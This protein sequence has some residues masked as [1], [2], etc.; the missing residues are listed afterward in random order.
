MARRNVDDDLNSDVVVDIPKDQEHRFGCLGR[1]LKPSRASVEALIAKIPCGMVMTTSCLRNALAESYNA[2][3]TC[4]FL[5]NRALMAIAADPK[6]KAPFWRV[7][8]VNGEMVRYF[9]GGGPEQ[10]RRLKKEGVVIEDRRERFGVMN[11]RD[12]QYTEQLG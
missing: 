2:Q 3:V 9:P 5:T 7:V 10:A 1:M 6:T 4:P 12:K 11:L 8:T